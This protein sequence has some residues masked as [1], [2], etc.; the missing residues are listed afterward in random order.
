MSLLINAI[1]IRKDMLYFNHK[2]SQ[3][4]AYMSIS[5][6]NLNQLIMNTI[7][8]NDEI[9][10]ISGFFSVDIIENIAKTGKPT[11]FYYGM[12][13]KNGLSLAYYNAFKRLKCLY[14]NLTILIP[15][16]YHVHTKCYIFKT[17][18]I[19]TQAFVGSANCSSSALNTTPNSELLM[20]V[21]TL[22]DKNFLEQYALEILK[23][24]VPFDDPSIFPVNKSKKLP[25][26]AKRSKTTPKSWNVYSGNPFSAIIPLY[27]MKKNK[28]IVHEKD[29]LNW[30]NGPH[31]SKSP[32]MEAI[33]PI[34]K[35]QIENHPLLIPFNGT[36]GS[37]S[38]GKIQRMQN[39]IDVIWD[40]STTMKM[41]FQ[42]GG[43]EIPPK[44]KRTSKMTYRQYPKAL[45]ANSGGEEL[46]IYFRSHLGL[47]PSAVVAYEDLRKY[48][49]DYVTLTLTAAGNYELDFSV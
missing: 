27:Y 40:D 30:G 26:V 15:V 2:I 41:I 45:T 38:G 12:Y 4:R 33:I 35:F 32:N 23:N 39:P 34:R 36:V 5:V 21:D 13:L 29:G 9:T 11:T 16:A 1:F 31:S 37:G 25:V 10:I 24:S 14:P 18:G 8:Q 22:S 42:Q 7:Q 19:I 3:R 44:G 48:G 49:R 28:P 6:K 17:N 43:V 47:S 46:G 20:P